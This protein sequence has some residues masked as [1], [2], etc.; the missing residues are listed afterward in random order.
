M[1]IYLEILHGDFLWNFVKGFSK[2][3]VNIFIHKTLVTTVFN[4]PGLKWLN[5]KLDATN[6]NSKRNKIKLLHKKR[7]KSC[8][9]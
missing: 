6:R 1:E 9:Y 8:N 7:E 3:I 2:P 5:I 4:N